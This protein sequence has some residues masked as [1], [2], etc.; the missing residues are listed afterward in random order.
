MTTAMS[1][2]DGIPPKWVMLECL[3]FRMDDE[4]YF[5]DKNKVPIRASGTTWWD[6]TFQVA[7]ELA[8]PWA[9]SCLYMRVGVFGAPMSKFVFTCLA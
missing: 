4:E 9:I 2:G 3:V 7:F 1:S 8:E 6:A 5:P